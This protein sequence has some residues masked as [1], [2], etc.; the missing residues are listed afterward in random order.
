MSQCLWQPEEREAKT[1]KY[2]NSF[3]CL[4]T[5]FLLPWPFLRLSKKGNLKKRKKRRASAPH[6][7]NCIWGSNV[8]LA[9]RSI[10]SRAPRR[11]SLGSTKRRTSAAATAHFWPRKIVGRTRQ[12]SRVP[13]VTALLRIH[14]ADR[15]HWS[16]MLKLKEGS[17]IHNFERKSFVSFL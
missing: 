12:G 5:Q 3:L 15:T 1:S 13:D 9:C 4:F 6:T 11:L 10:T 8:V 16:L 2:S 14:N 17:N 7:Y